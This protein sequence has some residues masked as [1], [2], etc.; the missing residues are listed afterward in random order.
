[1]AT[2][3]LTATELSNAQRV[4]LTKIFAVYQNQTDVL[5][6][7]NEE[8]ADKV[9]KK[10]LQVPIEVSPNPSLSIG[11][12]DGDA[13]AT[14]QA[15]D[16]DNFVVTYTNLNAGSNETYAAMLN[17]NVQTS[18]DVFRYQAESDAKQFS[19]FLND[20]ASRGDS[21]GTLATVSTNYAGGT[22]TLAVCNGPTDSIGVSQLVV[23]GYYTFWDATGATQR[24]GTVGAGAV[25]L[26]S[27]STTTAT[28]QT[29]IPSDVIA[30]DI[31]VPQ[32]TISAPGGN[33]V[34]GLPAI[35]NASNTYY[36]KNRATAANN[37][38]CSYVS[39][40]TT[41]T[42]GNLSTTY[43]SIAQRGGYFANGA[44]DLV[45]QMY[46]VLNMANWNAY[47]GLSLN[48][49]AVVSSP[50]VFRHTKGE[51][52]G[53][54]VGMSTVNFTWFGAPIKVANSVRGD[55]IYFM[56][57]KHVRRAVLKPVGFIPEGMPASD[58][59]QGVNSSGNYIMAR[60]RW[61]DWFGNIYSPQ[62]AMLG[63]L[64]LSSLNSPSQKSIMITSA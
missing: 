55:E 32:T 47:Y 5:G 20:Y 16:F 36:G 29:N 9:N 4:T 62:P 60:Y 44:T 56:N 24:T 17:N 43:A 57:P 19:K 3:S 48:A 59:L 18:E 6:W 42:A 54:D 2:Q 46:M 50:H 30:T 61:M 8:P 37:G 45:D 11:S 15:S 31:I 28:F 34:Y 27:K 49:G 58:W 22:P 26:G 64:V 1:M 13:F 39:S 41:L 38:L 23:G 63:K 14:A 25:Q 53:M 52:P 21:L 7:I 51:N 10:G 12:G 40:A 35:I 33:G